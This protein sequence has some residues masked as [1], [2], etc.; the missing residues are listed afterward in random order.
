MDLVKEFVMGALAAYQVEWEA[1]EKVFEEVG[2]TSKDDL[3]HIDWKADF[4]DF[5]AVLSKV[6]FR[7]LGKAVTET[8]TSP[9]P[10]TPQPQA[11]PPTRQ[12]LTPVSTN[13]N[14]PYDKFNEV[15]MTM[16]RSGRLI[17]AHARKLIL[18]QLGEKLVQT[19]PNISKEL[20]ANIA[21]QM[22]RELPGLADEG[23]DGSRHHTLY[24]KLDNVVQGLLRQKRVDSGVTRATTGRPSQRPITAKMQYGTKHFRPLSYGD[25]ESAATQ[26]EKR[27]WL[28][29]HFNTVKAG[30]R[31][32]D[33]VQLLMAQTYPSQ[34]MQ[35]VRAVQEET[36]EAVTK[37]WPFLSTAPMLKLHFRLLTEVDVD[38]RAEKNV[39]KLNAALT[40]YFHA[41]FGKKRPHKDAIGRCLAFCKNKAEDIQFV[42][43][44]FLAGVV[45]RDDLNSLCVFLPLT[46][47]DKPPKEV[48]REASQTIYGELEDVETQGDDAADDPLIKSR[49][50]RLVV[51]GHDIYNAVEA[52]PLIDGRCLGEQGMSVFDGLLSTFTLFYIFGRDYPFK[53]K[54]ML[55]F[56]Q[57]KVFEFEGAGSKVERSGSRKNPPPVSNNYLT[58]VDRV[59][60]YCEPLNVEF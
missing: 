15:H 40:A 19:N 27:T 11:P 17:S 48:A 20:L 5:S 29:T 30:D 50:I 38:A 58:F 22:V 46:L 16:L 36:E 56:I 59:R 44:L 7:V 60:Q 47:K 45:M 13:F 51:V 37:D 26:E 9:S 24:Q 23:G 57:R 6:Q 33:Q 41:E 25:G 14:I 31:D 54:G 3:A 8:A 42:C 2:V 55:D 4:G 39:K 1:L 32:D 35:I 43:L 53:C 28:S 18:H 52:Y 10:N 34:R 21:R 12:P 49:A